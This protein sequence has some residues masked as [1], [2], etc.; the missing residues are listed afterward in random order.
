[1]TTL[2]PL[3]A[4]EIPGAPTISVIG[5]GYLGAVH[6]ASMASLGFDVI[7]VEV[8][9]RSAELLAAG[10]A[11]FHEDGLPELLR[12]GVDSGRL[13]FTQHIEDAAEADVHFICVGTPQLDD[14]GAAD[15]SY[16][17][18]SVTDLARV[19]RKPA[20]IVG[21]STVPVG[22]AQALRDNVADEVRPGLP[23]E[24]IWNPEFL[25]ESKAV[26]DTLHPDRIV[27]GGTTEASLEVMERVYSAP[28][29][30]GS[31]LVLTDLQ[32]AELVKT[33]A[34]AFLATKIS[35]INSIA[36]MCNSVGA[37]IVD[38]A[39]A[40]GF[41]AR[42]GR[43][44]LN[45]GIGFGG[46]CLPKD[47]RALRH[48]ANEVGADALA[49]IL[50]DVDE[51]NLH[52]R[53]TAVDKVVKAVENS[54]S[55]GRKVAVLGAAFKPNTDDV[56]D[57]PALA[58]ARELAF[59][60]LEVEVY[61]PQARENARAYAPELTVVETLAEAVT[62]ASAVAVLTEWSEFSN[63][64]PKALLDLVDNPVV[65]DGRNCLPAADWAAAGWT[66]HQFGRPDR[67]P[68]LAEQT[69][70]LPWA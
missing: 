59:R 51:A 39:D 9:P 20:L 5:C 37:D 1:M 23:T 32:T 36:D 46:G 27:L 31:P 11:P 2:T 34:N 50:K 41:D 35:F 6:A 64:D 53:L 52:S 15:T 12:E 3:S 30:E 63:A 13:R 7:G 22:T 58:V 60:G 55:G 67:L 61:D 21:K 24:L 70:N 28:L 17:T 49:A 62:G 4:E 14:S 48:R 16:V 10:I 8:N 65:V 19:L 29:M 68:M 47:I 45:S 54:P 57:S 38:I 43:Q 56:R 44:F 33:A 26:H 18:Q 42:I 40:I 69:L 66:I 25:R